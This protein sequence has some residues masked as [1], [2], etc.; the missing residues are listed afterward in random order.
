MT[1]L[2]VIE[3]GTRLDFTIADI[4]RFHGPGF[5]GGVA[6]GIKVME[7]AFAL[8]SPDAPPERREISIRTAFRGPGGR[9]AFEIVT[10]SLTDGRYVVDAG[11]ERPE[12][13][14]I[15]FRYV[16]CVSYRGR[17]VQLQLRDAGHVREEFI[18]LGAKPT[19]TPDEDVRLAWLKSEMAERLLALPAAEVYE[20]F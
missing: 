15:L 12:R 9:D 6:H 14:T 2:S 13:G 1:T 19:R 8:L 18:R 10:R 20:E 5:P 7:R 4:M 3:A 17:T 16:F 11:L